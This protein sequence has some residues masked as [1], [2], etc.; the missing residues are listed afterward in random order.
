MDGW[1][2][3]FDIPFALTKAMNRCLE[4]I[5]L[6]GKMFDCNVQWVLETKDQGL[7]NYQR[8]LLRADVFRATMPAA[9]WERAVHI[10]ISEYGKGLTHDATWGHPAWERVEPAD[11]GRK[12]RRAAVEK[13]GAPAWN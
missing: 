4:N 5:P 10:A 7:R 12:V 13:R 8:E 11:G 3:K 9:V 1:I 2:A 6:A